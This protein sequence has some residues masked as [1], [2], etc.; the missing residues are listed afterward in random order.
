MIESETICAEEN[1][2]RCS[3]FPI[4]LNGDQRKVLKIR[5]NNEVVIYNGNENVWNIYTA[6]SQS[7]IN[8][9]CC[10]FFSSGG[11]F[12]KHIFI[13]LVDKIE[14]YFYRVFFF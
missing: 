14:F 3:R 5:D 4:V 8:V 6:S 1:D 9:G 12:E 7:Y 10:C 11:N 13:H 2:E